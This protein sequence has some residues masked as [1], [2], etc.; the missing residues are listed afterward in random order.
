MGDPKK[1]LVRFYY[2]DK[3]DMFDPFISYNKGGRI[4]NMLRNQVGDSAFYRSLNLFLTTKKFQSAEAHDL[5]LAF[6][7]V[8][9]QDLNW[10]WNQWYYG[11]G[12]PTLDIS[13]D[14]DSTGKT[15][16]VYLKQ[17]QPD[18]IF[19][20]QIA[21]DVYQGA[22]KKRYKVW[23]DQPVDTVS[24]P[25]ASKPDLINVDGDKILLCE[26]TDHKTLDNFIFQYQ[27][28]GLY[29]DR[30]EAIDFASKQKDAKSL[31]L[32]TTAL[33][34]KYK[35]LRIYAIQKL[36]LKN[37][38]VKNAVEPLLVD[39]ANNDKKSLVRAAAID[40]LGKYK[41][42]VYKEFFLKSINDSSYSVAGNAL[43]ALG[44]LDSITALKQAII[45]A[46]QP[47]KGTLMGAINTSLYQY[48]GESEFD[49]L[50]ARFDNL[51]TWNAKYN[52]ASYFVNFLKRVQ[53]T[54]NFR[55]GIDM[56]VNLRDSAPEQYHQQYISFINGSFLNSIATAKRSMGM[57]DQADYVASILPVSKE[58]PSFEVSLENLKKYAGEYDFNGNIIKI[59]LNDDKAL[60]FIFA[61]EPEVE[62]IPLLKNKF[63]LKYME[64]QSIEF[65]CNEKDEVIELVLTFAGGQIKAIKKK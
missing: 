38:S 23:V 11:S 30:L 37:D 8:T 19:K 35:G 41:K 34:D 52:A 16:K 1:D 26:K 45:L 55:K 22:E 28:A 10:F 59:I 49:M 31:E 21:V 43:F 53:N 42:E 54:T 24:F 29:V 14:Y 48:S 60:K 12:H 3:E 63:A 9:G 5:R 61:T 47:A 51:P 39:L 15:A 57:N 2:K 4:L 58:L 18:K 64:D 7:E 46:A 40:A 65:I 13:Y 50:A 56:I 62:L 25:A 44:T 20:F 36:D 32:M 33:K 6:E 17:T 27:N